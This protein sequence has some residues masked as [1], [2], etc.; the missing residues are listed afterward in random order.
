[1]GANASPGGDGGAPATG[2][3]RPERALVAVVAAALLALLLATASTGPAQVN[4]TRASMLASWSLGTQGELAL[5]EVWPASRNYWGVETADGRVHV[6]RF[7]GAALWAAPAY[8]VAGVIDPATRAP[9]HP[10]LVDPR[11]AAAT[12]A[13]TV[14][15][16]ALL[17]YLLLRRRWGPQ[18]AAV[19]TLT[20][21]LGTSLWSVAADAL[22]PHGPSALA[23]LV[24]LWGVD[25]DRPWAV[26]VGAAVSITIRPHLVV[27]WVVTGAVLLLPRWRTRRDRWRRGPGRAGSAAAPVD[28]RTPAGAT[29]VGAAVGLAVVAGYSAAVFGTWYPAAGYDVTDHLGG[30]VRHDLEQTL[31]A[32]GGV[33]GGERGVL[34]YSPVV[35]VATIATLRHRR[36]IPAWAVAATLGGLAYLLVQVR[37]VGP[38]GGTGFFG[39]R[40][41]TE[42]VVLAL[43]ALVAGSVA[44]AR[45]SRVWT[46]TLL[47]AA[48]L[49]VAVNGVGAVRGG[50]GP[51]EVARWDEVDASV[52]SAYGD[53]VLG[54]VDLREV[55]PTRLRSAE[56][57][58]RGG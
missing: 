3:G 34:R 25:R 26:V 1:M 28:R 14:T 18:V 17:A 31:T 53:R 46:V 40:V 57:D 43:P 2:I 11:P 6:N 39:P 41:T 50:S 13:A 9:A 38:L 27:A 56:A 48:A 7:P 44:A 16:A 37:A 22:W 36:E 49:S 52:R 47:I 19:A 23:L 20:V 5:P 32:V 4:D 10:F 58:V 24:A 8:A 55:P 12:A 42:T 33:L 35:A 29:L 45:T 54:E 15:A 21:T 51:S 30:L